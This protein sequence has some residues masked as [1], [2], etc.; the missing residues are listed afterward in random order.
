LATKAA[1]SKAD[2]VQAA[3][4]DALD[5]IARIERRVHPRQA[6][7][8]PVPSRLHFAVDFVPQPELTPQTYDDIRNQIAE[9]IVKLQSLGAV[10]E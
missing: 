3:A 9:H 7:S 6:Y 10:I 4:T 8:K 1:G 5:L 2:A